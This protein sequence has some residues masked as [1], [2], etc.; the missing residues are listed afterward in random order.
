MYEYVMVYSII[1]YVLNYTSTNV[2]VKVQ[3]P[4]VGSCIFVCMCSILKYLWKILYYYMMYVYTNKHGGS[5]YPTGKGCVPFLR[6]PVT[7]E[8]TKT[9]NMVNTIRTFRFS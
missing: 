3:L 1:V 7:V 2:A 8:L 5:H 6:N 4:N 9:Q